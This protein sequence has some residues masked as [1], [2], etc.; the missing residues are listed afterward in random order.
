MNETSLKYACFSI[1]SCSYNEFVNQGE[2]INGAPDATTDNDTHVIGASVLQSVNGRACF[3][4]QI[5]QVVT[6]AANISYNVNDDDSCKTQS[7]NIITSVSMLLTFDFH[8]S[9]MP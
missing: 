6:Y 7:G 3:A 1:G 9:V 8:R 4:S 2:N 5:D